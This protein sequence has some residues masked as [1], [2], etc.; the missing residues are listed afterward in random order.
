[1]D[2]MY[3]LGRGENI[4]QEQEVHGVGRVSAVLQQEGRARCEVLSPWPYQ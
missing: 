3:G 2:S 1:M 4:Y